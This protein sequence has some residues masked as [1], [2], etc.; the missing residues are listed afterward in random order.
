MPST[1]DRAMRS[2]TDAGDVRRALAERRVMHQKNE[3]L[4]ARA[5]ALYE[6]L[7]LLST[8]A[9]QARCNENAQVDYPLTSRAAMIADIIEYEEGQCPPTP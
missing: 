4:E 1:P 7:R 3:A 8:E 2:L 6:E 9:L 5:S